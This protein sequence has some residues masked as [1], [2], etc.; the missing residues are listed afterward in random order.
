MSN[1]RISIND[2]PEHLN[3]FNE[4]YNEGLATG[5]NVKYHTWS[6]S[7]RHKIKQAFLEKSWSAMSPIKLGRKLSFIKAVTVDKLSPKKNKH[8][9]RP[10]QSANALPLPVK[11]E[12]EPYLIISPKQKEKMRQLALKSSSTQSSD[13]GNGFG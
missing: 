7:K 8:K 10:V 12:A 13:S 6:S 3:P 2:Y 1:R 11:D 5:H 4:F 9:L